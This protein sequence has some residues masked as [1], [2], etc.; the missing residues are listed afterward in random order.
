MR[1]NLT[2]EFSGGDLYALAKDFDQVVVSVDGNEQTHNA[3][4]GAGA[5]ANMVGNL[6]RYALVASTVRGAA[7]LSLA[8]VM[9]AEDVNGEPGKM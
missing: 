4:R 8:C 9:S 5:Y 2:G 7:E 6:E 1:T 3:R